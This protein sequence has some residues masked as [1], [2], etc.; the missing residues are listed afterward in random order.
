MRKKNLKW[1]CI[2]LVSWS[3]VFMIF[4]S[5]INYDIA[6][7]ISDLK[8]IDNIYA[9]RFFSER[10]SIK[11]KFKYINWKKMFAI[12]HTF[13]L[14]YK[15]WMMNCV[16]L[17]YD[18]QMMIDAL[19]KKSIKE[20]IIQSLQIIFLIAMIFNIKITIFWISLKENIVMNITSQYDFKKLINLRFQ[21]QIFS[22][23][24]WDSFTRISVL[25]QK[26]RIFCTI[27][28]LQ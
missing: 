11:H 20:S 5:W 21:D 10:I 17:M 3:S 16:H 25:H 6:I 2:F 24:H 28:L 1:W 27:S 13:T 4:L 9:N 23:H 14:W 8:D 7:D 22:L 26:L 12:L 18:N 19:N 15:E